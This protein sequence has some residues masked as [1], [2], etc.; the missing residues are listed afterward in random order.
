MPLKVF[1]I[2]TGLNDGGAEA[3]LYRLCTHD[4]QNSHFVISMMDDG[5]YGPLLRAS[6]VEVHCLGMPR[7]RITVSA[8]WRLW[9]LLRMQRPEIVQTWMY[10]A[11]LVGGTI[12]RLAGVNAVCW[13]IHHTSLKREFS[14]R[15]TIVVAHLCARLSGWVPSVIITSSEESARVHQKLGYPNKKFSVIP[16]GYDLAYFAPNSRARVRL[17]TEWGIR[18]ETPLIGMVARH[19][20]QKDHVNLIAALSQLRDIGTVF[21]C[22]LVGTGVDSENT[23]LR[24]AIMAAGLSHIIRLLG[25]RDDIPAVMNALDLHVLS[26]SF[27]EA[28]PNV[29]AE[30]MACGTPCVTTNVGDASLI[31]GDIGWVAPPANAEAL[32]ECIAKALEEMKN[33][34]QWGN[35]CKATRERVATNFSITRMVE[36]YRVI[37]AKATK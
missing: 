22:V 7:G 11:D 23:S 31:V 3:V 21:D 13:G 20:A 36:N 17:R 29:L 27:G 1:H 18:N 10:H 15:S 32:A 25:R 28:F 34:M 4:T 35:R 8:L 33:S 26:S 14:A 30:A 6:G 16:S 2:I 37:W 5:K 19:D 12:A 24:N 9:H